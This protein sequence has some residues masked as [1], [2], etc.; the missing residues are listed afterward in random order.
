M[1]VYNFEYECKDTTFCEEI[2]REL[3]PGKYKIEAWGAS[4]GSNE[5]CKGGPGGYASVL[6]TL[7]TKKTIYINIGGKGVYGTDQHTQGG[8]NGG[9]LGYKGTMSTGH[10]SGG[11]AT[12]VRFNHTLESRFLVA[13]G[14]G[15]FGTQYHNC[16]IGGFGGGLIGGD[17][18]YSKDIKAKGSGANQTAGGQKGTSYTYGDGTDGTLGKGGDAH[19]EAYGGG[20]GGGGYYGGGGSYEC[21]GGGGSSF[22]SSSYNGLTYSGEDYF[23]LPDGNY[24]HGNIGNGFV[25][26]TK[27]FHSIAYYQKYI[28]IFLVF[29][30]SLGIVS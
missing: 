23:Q 20:G 19:G 18:N 10:S 29:Q 5:S 8:N 2:E 22:I 26:I 28:S 15:G 24:G 12:D 16:V 6:L 27:Y 7:Y 4:G 1:E 13:A 9:G 11:G 30:I 21:G 3:K 14:G 25:R 17:G